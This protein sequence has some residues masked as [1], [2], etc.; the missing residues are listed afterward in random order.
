MNE[1]LILRYGAL[2]QV[3]L[4]NKIK[5]YATLRFVLPVVKFEPSSYVTR[6]FHL[7]ED[8]VLNSK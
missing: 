6:Q 2:Q 8:N 5:P 4:G 1:L 7:C 3:G